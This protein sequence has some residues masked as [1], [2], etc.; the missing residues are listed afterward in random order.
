[1][2]SRVA[3]GAVE[4][5]EDKKR[6]YLAATAAAIL[7]LIHYLPFL[8][9]YARLW[10]INHL[11]F[12]P[13]VWAYGYFVGGCLILLIFIPAARNTVSKLYRSVAESLFERRPR[14]VL[15]LFAVGA[16]AI[17]W[18]FRSPIKLLGDSQAVIANIGNEI[19]V[20]VK[21][22]EKASVYIVYAVSKLLP[23]TGAE[24]GRDAYEIVSVVSGSL[25]LLFAG[26][27]AC[28]LAETSVRRLFIFA[29][30][31]F[32]GW[33]VLFF[34][35]TENYPLFWIFMTGYIY[36]GIKYIKGRSNLLWP[37]VFLLAA[38]P[39][40]T[41][42][43][44]FSVSYLI[45]LFSRG[46]ARRFYARRK[47]IVW[48]AAAFLA[49]A[50]MAV[51]A[52][53]YRDSLQFSLMIIPLL[54]GRP[55]TPGYWLLSP[56]HLLDIV[57]EFLLVAPLL[58]VLAILGWKSP[59]SI[60]ADKSGL[61]LGVLGLGGLVFIF[62]IDPK[63][64][65]AR[66]W[67]LFAFAG[68]PPLL[69]FARNVAQT[70]DGHSGIYAAVVL[71][72]GLM[73]LPWVATNLRFQPAVD[74]FKFMLNLDLPRCRSAI[75]VLRQ[76]YLVGGDSTTAD[77]LDRVIN[78]EFP[79]IH[80]C[81]N[82]EELIRQGRFDE[83]KILIDSLETRDP[84]MVEFLTMRG[85]W[86]LKRHDYYA[87]LKDHEQAAKLQDCN[88]LAEAN[89]AGVYFALHRYEP[90]IEALRRGQ[91][92][93][94]NSKEILVGLAAGFNAM[95]DYDSATA[96]ARKLM[97]L[98]PDEPDAYYIFGM[99]ALITGR[100]ETAR[101]H[102]GRYLELAPEGPYAKSAKEALRKLK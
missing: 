86:N 87:A 22:S 52:V 43:L 72:A 23:S 56:A 88:P 21:W 30:I 66:D 85:Y 94:P 42:A 36:Y 79:S 39:I 14:I 4:E 77:S 17:F 37:T 54:R 26:G 58:P 92:Y 71:A 5:P 34:G 63:L 9:P 1:L 89:V 98:Y 3:P 33:I 46:R 70:K 101:S 65:M 45:L 15:I 24:L 68:L 11:L 100:A 51:F 62:T 19:P 40:H 102:L 64:G 83:A 53:A 80:L 96:Y 55:M 60:I 73:V 81:R 48:A 41:Q 20:I 13:T 75:I 57:N 74:D 8:F 10:G 50:G 7:W 47:K 6:M 95:K 28:E 31:L 91:R 2:E 61:F 99:T 16:A 69:L 84:T 29:L 49:V 93:D 67:D 59:R 18:I 12:L 76:M 44:F 78:R 25:T 27:I 32:A 97:E 38:I 82:A 35:Y 90:M